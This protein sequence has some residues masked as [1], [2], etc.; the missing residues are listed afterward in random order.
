M[1]KV[2]LS[3]L[4]TGVAA[5]GFAQ[6]NSTLRVPHKEGV[7]TTAPSNKPAEVQPN[8][9]VL[10]ILWTE[11]FSGGTNPLETGNGLYSVDGAN[12]SY[13]TV[14]SSGTHPL[15]GFGFGQN[16]NGEHARW[17]SYGPNSNEPTGQFATTPV[18]GGLISPT[19]ALTGNTNSIG[20]Q[21]ST[22]AIYCCN[23]NE[24]A[25]PFG[26]SVSVDDGVSWSDTLRFD[27]G[28]DRNESTQDIAD[29]LTVGV[30]LDAIAPAGPQATFKFKFV[31][32]GDSQDGNGQYNTHYSWLIDDISIYEIP[33]NDI[34][35]T[36]GYH[37]DIIFDWEYSMLP[38][39]QSTVREMV[40][41]LMVENQ[42]IVDQTVD[43]TC[44]IRDG[45]NNIVNTTVV[46]QTIV[47][48]ELDTI[49]FQTGYMPSA[50]DTY[51][52][53]FSIPADDDPT[54]DA[55]DASDLIV[56]QNLMAHDYGTDSEFSWDPNGNNS[57]LADAPHAYGNIYVPAVDQDAYGMNVAFGGGMDTDLFLIA[58]IQE[59]TGASIQ[60][61]LNPI[62]ETG[63]QVANGEPGNIVT[64]VFDNPVSLTAGT[65][66]IVDIYKV[67]GTSGLEF[68]ID[69]TDTNGEDDDFSTVNYGPYGQN[70]AVNYFNGWGYAP[71]VRLN[72][73]MSLNV[74]ENAT[75][76][77]VSVY[78]NPTEGLINVTN[79][80]NTEQTIEVRNLSG[81][82]I[83]METVSNATTIDLAGEAAGMYV[84]KVSN[85][86]GSMVEKIAVK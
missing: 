61:P 69:G 10:N 62:V 56:D 59:M 8:E 30:N 39:A 82:L 47:S 33:D 73:D 46:Q 26:I 77:G 53:S 3:F 24:D 78:P 4:L 6:E 64:I 60:D 31:W 23:F 79:D 63:H 80:N 41:V 14:S 68:A 50:L 7:I 57:D 27:F 52:T 5:S 71:H 34:A 44:E 37:N 51:S 2:Y 67:D 58:R 55:I 1:K 28:I 11:D 17:N 49:Y 83:Y 13:W 40:P 22:D 75:L 45:G 32:D 35:L 16:M 29:P 65:S 18:I 36:D 15:S 76:E 85:E 66:Y 38:L 9:K 12:G 74:G 81:Q 54:D 42:G 19:I 48:G 43:F 86:N 70:S 25:R 21:F 20:I 84:V 72:F